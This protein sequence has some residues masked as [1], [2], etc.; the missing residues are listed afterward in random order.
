MAGVCRWQDD[1]NPVTRI[2]APPIVMAL[3]GD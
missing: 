1:C 2:D 3:L